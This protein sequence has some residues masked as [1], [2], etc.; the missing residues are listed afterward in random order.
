[1]KT[2]LKAQELLVVEPGRAPQQ[3][4]AAAAGGAGGGGRR[5]GGGS[6]TEEDAL[7][8]RVCYRLAAYADGRYR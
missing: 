7:A 1:M 4:A 6:Q 3:G 2:M 5:G 8:C